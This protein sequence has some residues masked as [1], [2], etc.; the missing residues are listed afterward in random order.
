MINIKRQQLEDDIKR[1]LEVIERSLAWADQYGKESFNR[2]ELKAYRRAVKK[3]KFAMAENCSAA[4]Y[5]ES[6]VGKSYLMDSLL[7]DPNKPFE[8]ING[9]KSYSFINQISEEAFRTIAAPNVVFTA[10]IAASENLEILGIL[11]KKMGNLQ[12][13]IRT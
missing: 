7:G 8:I 3:I 12:F 4:A 13:T 5:G 6:Q 9:G 11:C 10:R 2:A 1:Q